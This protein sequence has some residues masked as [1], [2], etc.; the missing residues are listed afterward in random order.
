M[1]PPLNNEERAR[2]PK[3]S[4]ETPGLGW[5]LLPMVPR[6]TSRLSARWA[7]LQ[8]TLRA[9]SVSPKP[10]ALP[11]PSPAPRPSPALPI[12]LLLP[13]ITPAPSS[14]FFRATHHSVPPSSPPCGT[15]GSW[16]HRVPVSSVH[17]PS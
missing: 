14:F 3:S 15:Q 8:R 5:E 11:S 17:P 13:S 2:T 9:R 6:E 10:R 4:G 7:E 12:P 16:D 1:Q